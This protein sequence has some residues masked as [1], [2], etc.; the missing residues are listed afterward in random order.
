MPQQPQHG[1]WLQ[2]IEGG[3][4]EV[5]ILG[6]DLVN[7]WNAYYAALAA[8]DIGQALVALNTFE[9]ETRRLRAWVDRQQGFNAGRDNTAPTAE[10][11][12]AEMKQDLRN[13]A[14]PA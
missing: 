7:P 8:P 2:N 4:P 1:Q 13:A 6:L 9:A 12:L 5:V 11:V 10:A 14:P 3:V